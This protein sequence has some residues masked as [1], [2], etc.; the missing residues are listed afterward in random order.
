MIAPL[1][2]AARTIAKGFDL[3]AAAQGLGLPEPAEGAPGE[4]AG[5]IYLTAAA[6]HAGLG[7]PPDPLRPKGWMTFGRRLEHDEDPEPG[8][9]ALFKMKDVQVA[10][11]LAIWDRGWHVITAPNEMLK[12]PRTALIAVRRPIVIEG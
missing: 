9:V 10:G 1:I 12:A 8:D 7:L 5:L 11:I 3:A 4:L 6:A 2:A